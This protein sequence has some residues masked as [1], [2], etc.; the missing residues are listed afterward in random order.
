[1][2]FSKR[3]HPYTFV[4]KNGLVAVFPHCVPIV[5]NMLKMWMKELDCMVFVNY[6]N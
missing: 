3:L 6:V 1:M 2:T 4:G 5:I